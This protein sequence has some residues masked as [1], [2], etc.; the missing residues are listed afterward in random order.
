MQKYCLLQRRDTRLTNL[1]K[2]NVT[3]RHP[4]SGAAFLLG[5]VTGS[6]NSTGRWLCSLMLLVSLFGLNCSGS[7]TSESNDSNIA[8][9]DDTE[10]MRFTDGGADSATT[11]NTEADRWSFSWPGTPIVDETIF[12]QKIFPNRDK[13]R[14][15]LGGRHICRAN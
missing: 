15:K 3:R 4:L 9:S 10:S 7:K 13:Y 2:G 1:T 11:D 8:D 12:E 14:K 6:L 5:A